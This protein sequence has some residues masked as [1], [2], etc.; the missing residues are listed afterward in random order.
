Y[1]MAVASTVTAEAPKEKRSVD[2]RIDDD[3]PISSGASIGQEVA[4]NWDVEDKE[5]WRT[6]AR[7]WYA[8]G[9]TEKPGEGR[10]QHH[11]AL[12]CRDVRG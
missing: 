2:S 12:L 5:T 4:D 9:I 3:E 10:L 6:T 7:D 8:M 11:L 1:R